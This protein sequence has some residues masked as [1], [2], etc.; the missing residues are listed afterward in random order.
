MKFVVW[1]TTFHD[2]VPLGRRCCKKKGG[3]ET[4]M[5][6]IGFYKASGCCGRFMNVWS[7]RGRNKEEKGPP[8]GTTPGGCLGEQTD[9]FLGKR[10]KGFGEK[11]L[12]CVQTK[13]ITK[14]FTL[15]GHP[16]SVEVTWRKRL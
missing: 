4:R 12:G 7:K 14:L 11:L 6:Y 1:D 8:G 9:H 5:L 16:W 3:D 2:F 10:K 15:W 13:K